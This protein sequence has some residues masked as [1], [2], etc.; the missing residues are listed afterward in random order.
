MY[1]SFGCRGI[2]AFHIFGNFTL[3]LAFTGNVI[4]NSLPIISIESL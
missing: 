2:K 1:I 3:L 4:L